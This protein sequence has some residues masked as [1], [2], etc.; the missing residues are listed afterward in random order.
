MFGIAL[1]FLFTKTTLQ[2]VNKKC[3]NVGLLK[4]SSSR[5]I[6]STSVSILTWLF[7]FCTL[8]EDRESDAFKKHDAIPSVKNQTSSYPQAGE[9]YFAVGYTG[10][11][12]D[13]VDKKNCHKN[14]D[15]KMT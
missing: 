5:I 11:M 1:Y 6:V 4:D 3:V 12:Q 8:V 2:Q 13:T 15:E 14:V 7:D 9:G 10:C